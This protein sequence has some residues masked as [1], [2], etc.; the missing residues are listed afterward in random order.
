MRNRRRVACG[1]AVDSVDYLTQCIVASRVDISI[2]LLQLYNNN[3]SVGAQSIIC[4]LESDSMHHRFFKLS[5]VLTST[6][7]LS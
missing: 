3:K 1:L 2:T 7:L 6:R 4:L 5:C